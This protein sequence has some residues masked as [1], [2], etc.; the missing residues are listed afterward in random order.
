[1]EN[2]ERLLSAGITLKQAQDLGK[3]YLDQ[4]VTEKINS[5]TLMAWGAPIERIIEY[6]GAP[7][8]A[9]G[10][11]EGVSIKETIYNQIKSDLHRATRFDTKSLPLRASYGLGGLAMVSSFS[12]VVL[13]GASLDPGLV[14]RAGEAGLV[15]EKINALM[16][17]AMNVMGVPGSEALSANAPLGQLAALCGTV[18]YAEHL[19]KKG[20]ST[21]ANV[22]EKINGP[23][24]GVTEDLFH[25]SR[26]EELDAAYKTLTESDKHLLSHLSPHET[27]VVLLGSDAAARSILKA[28]PTPFENELLAAANSN[29][30]WG[31]HFCKV[32]YLSLPKAGREVVEW[33]SSFKPVDPGQESNPSVHDDGKALLS[34]LAK[35]RLS[36]ASPESE[37]APA[38]SAGISAPSPR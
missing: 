26:L 10:L 19:R 12:L 8:S 11:A 3:H 24:S 23:S 33:L 27:R 25:G 9:L 32:M 21:G 1:M 28:N 16:W 2:R 30:G 36:K 35:R 34:R 31:H 20:M 37:P 18:A 4:S 29:T 17:K 15:F 7:A 5:K 38:V 6:I 22:R 13:A 14:D